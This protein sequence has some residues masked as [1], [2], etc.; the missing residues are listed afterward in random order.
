M[1]ELEQIA[2]QELV[3]FRVCTRVG[4]RTGG[5]T[6][7]HSGP[8]R[9]PEARPAAPPLRGLLVAHAT[10]QP[11]PLQLPALP[12]HPVPAKLA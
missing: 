6:L 5:A 2:W 11:Q 10:Q 4:S 7:A 1:P 3:L 12:L 9:G 8:A